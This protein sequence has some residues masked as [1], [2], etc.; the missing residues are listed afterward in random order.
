[1]YIIYHEPTKRSFLYNQKAMQFKQTSLHECE[2]SLRH[3]LCQDMIFLRTTGVNYAAR[4][5]QTP[6]YIDQQMK[7]KNPWP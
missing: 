7:Q 4:Q 3:L 1:M 6:N 5:R 2:W